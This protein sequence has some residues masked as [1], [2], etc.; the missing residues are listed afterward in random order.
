MR[1]IALASA[2]AFGCTGAALA[3]TVVVPVSVYLSVTP[4][5]KV[6]TPDAA[7]L[8]P[9]VTAA[10]EL[11][12]GIADMLPQVAVEMLLANCQTGVK[13]LLILANDGRSGAYLATIDF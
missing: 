2:L 1:A 6:R 3:N 10:L 4:A 12:A 9:A 8:K 5:C 13:P 7:A 11:P